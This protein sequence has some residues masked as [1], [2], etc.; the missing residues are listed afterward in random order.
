ML[1]SDNQI[2]LSEIKHPVYHIDMILCIVWCWQIVQNTSMCDIFFLTLA[3][4][5]EVHNQFP[6][7]NTNVRQNDYF[8]AQSQDRHLTVLPMY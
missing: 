6:T 2:I 3:R 8:G 1:V 4:P 7:L 5:I